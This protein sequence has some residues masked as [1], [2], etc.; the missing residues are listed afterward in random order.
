MVGVEIDCQNKSNH[1][2]LPFPSGI[3]NIQITDLNVIFSS[4]YGICDKRDLIC[5][6]RK[7]ERY[8]VVTEVCCLAGTEH[9]QVF[10]VDVEE[11]GGGRG[12]VWVTVSVEE[13]PTWRL[14]E[15][16]LETS[17]ELSPAMA[18]LGG[19]TQAEWSPL[20]GPDHVRYWA[21]IGGHI[22]M[23]RPSSQP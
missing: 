6:M 14:V 13:S 22:I 5:M 7:W 17:L 1:F 10:R 15:R 20:I 19:R 16:D 12:A 21:L 11:V 4:C 2:I 3:L 9:G 23:L 8:K 18:V